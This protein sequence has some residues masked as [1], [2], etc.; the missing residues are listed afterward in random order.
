[1]HNIH[2]FSVALVAVVSII[3]AVLFFN[4]N[5]QQSEFSSQAADKS[6][7]KLMAC[8]TAAEIEKFHQEY[9]LQVSKIGFTCA[10][11]D[12]RAHLYKALATIDRGSYKPSAAWDAE[13]AA[14]SQNIK[15]YIRK[16]VK[17]ISLSDK[18][19]TSTVVNSYPSESWIEF[20]D[21]I[22][23]LNPIEMMSMLVH[24]VRHIEAP[25]RVHS[26][27]G[28]GDMPGTEG[29][30][31]EILMAEYKN[32]SS[33][34]LEAYYLAGLAMFSQ[35]LNEDEKKSA[36][37]I[38]LKLI[39]GR[40]NNFKDNTVYFHDVVFRLTSEHKLQVWHTYLKQW[41]SVPL[42]IGKDQIERIETANDVFNVALF[43]AQGKFYTYSLFDGLKPY[44]KSLAE[45][46]ISDASRIV[47][48]NANDDSYMSVLVDGKAKI[49][50]FK[51]KLGVRPLLEYPFVEAGVANNYKF[52]KIIYGNFNEV[53]WLDE[54]GRLFRKTQSKGQVPDLVSVS[55]LDA[56]GPWRQGVAGLVYEDL[57]LVN[58]KGEIFNFQVKNK[59]TPSYLLEDEIQPERYELKPLSE[60]KAVQVRKFMQG[61]F[62][63]YILNAKGEIVLKRHD[64]A[65]TESLASAG[66]TAPAVDFAVIKTLI[67]SGLISDLLQV[68]LAEFKAKCAL[69]KA[70]WDPVLYKGMG[71]NK[72]GNLVF[73]DASGECRTLESVSGVSA[74]KFV[75]ISKRTEKTFTDMLKN[76]INYYS[77]VELAVTAK[78]GN[79]RI[80]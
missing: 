73:A 51:N 15:S 41:L 69:V 20:T 26:R 42:D 10:A 50:G 21:R 78:A 24:E 30:C 52:K 9:N 7:E 5:E 59:K 18:A 48:P 17:K 46:R 40:F 1:M 39:A 57:F 38:A 23:E 80:K 19:Q 6:N 25:H 22:L 12:P 58:E 70:A 2:R 44:S 27:C 37:Q 14:T 53:L 79:L 29:A 77:D 56:K 71:I 49:M 63:D 60:W 13:F 35:K 16:Y 45:H 33:Y 31:D 4:F 66:G 43:T 62:G 28:P 3:W 11:D 34:N 32:M 54:R 74:F 36:A 67:P 8:P 47:V 76:G 72:N 61:S 65:K 68:P 64:A 75:N 55:E